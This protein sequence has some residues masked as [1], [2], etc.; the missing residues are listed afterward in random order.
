MDL[1]G[2]QEK[3][4]MNELFNIPKDFWLRECDEVQ[5][6]FEQQV[7]SDL[8]VSIMTELNALR[9]RLQSN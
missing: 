6:Y 1:K 8:P 7:G 4:D 5:T 3:I 9:K 2:L